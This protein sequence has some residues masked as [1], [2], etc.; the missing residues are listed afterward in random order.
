MPA[1]CPCPRCLTPLSHFHNLGTATDR[2]RRVTLARVDDRGR[3]NSV[4]AARKLIYE[5]HQQVNS[6]AVENLLKEPSLVP[7]LVRLLP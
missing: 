1:L 7:N 6:T 2:Q 5:R 3:Q 4:F